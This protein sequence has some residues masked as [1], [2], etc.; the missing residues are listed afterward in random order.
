MAL[1]KPQNKPG[2]NAAPGHILDYQASERAA[3]A[4][5]ITAE[6][7][8]GVEAAL[9]AIRKLLP[10]GIAPRILICGSLY[11]GGTVLAA[12]GTLPK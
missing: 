5:G 9:A 4:A 8:S 3:E 11:L 12:N 6:A 2:A 10:P 1:S 7:T